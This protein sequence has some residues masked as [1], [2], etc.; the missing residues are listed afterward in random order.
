[1]CKTSGW[2]WRRAEISSLSLN[3][4]WILV[5]LGILPPL[6]VYLSIWTC[7]PGGILGVEVLSG[8][9]A[10]QYTK[11][12]QAWLGRRWRENTMYPLSSI[13]VSPVL[14]ARAQM[15]SS[16][17][18]SM[19]MWHYGSSARLITGKRGTE[20]K[21]CKEKRRHKEDIQP[22]FFF[23]FYIGNRDLYPD[24]V[25]NTLDLKRWFWSPKIRL[26]TINNNLFIG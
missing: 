1:M 20:T 25:D 23:F 11:G 22:C 24:F 3:T 7:S 12:R 18:L 13:P 26:N 17:S 8:L 5:F 14:S 4:C 16:V 2:S 21:G 6:N 9:I 15:F 10:M 19:T